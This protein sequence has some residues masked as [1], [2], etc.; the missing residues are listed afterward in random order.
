MRKSNAFQLTILTFMNT[1]NLYQSELKE[2]KKQFEAIDQDHSGT[3]DKQEM[4]NIMKPIL[5]TQ[6][7][8]DLE[9]LLD[10]MDSDKSGNINYSEF[11]NLAVEKT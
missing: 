4:I 10:S 2:I 5:T 11:I 7:V 9:R 6:E 1:L 8:N 3:L